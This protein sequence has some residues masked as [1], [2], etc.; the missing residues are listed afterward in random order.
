MLGPLKAGGPFEMRISGKSAALVF[1]NVMVG[2]VWVCSGQSNMAFAMRKAA[3]AEEET[4]KADY[5]GIRYFRAE[6][7]TSEKPAE[8]VRG[9][10][11]VCTAE[12]VVDFSAV[13]YFLARRL[14]PS[15]KKE[16][17]ERLALAALGTVYGKDIVWSGPLF[18][19]L[20]RAGNK[21]RITFKYVGSGLTTND[22]KPLRDFAVAGADG[23]FTAA[24]AE[25]QGN[26]VVVW[27]EGVKAPVSVRYSWADYPAGNLLN[28][29]GLP[30][31][32]FAASLD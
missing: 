13:A 24:T 3:S 9:K 14:H 10:W 2:E 16:V 29:E 18:H 20:T 6:A 1:G 26:A 15:R 17:G 21:L 5:P 22:S 7:W 11:Q 19:R 30:A 27:S 28:K 31:S 32:P 23:N 25:I 12:N 8:T 4:P